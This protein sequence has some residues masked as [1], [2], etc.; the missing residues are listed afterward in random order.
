MLHAGDGNDQVRSGGENDRINLGRGN[1]W[2]V[3]GAGNDRVLSQGGNNLIIGGQGADW[4]RGAAGGDLL[5][6]GTTV[7]DNDAAALNALL[8]EWGSTR[9]LIV[10]RDNIR[11][12]SGSADRL[13]QTY[14]LNPTTIF[15]DGERN[16]LVNVRNDDWDLWSS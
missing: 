3:A 8:A 4:L 16:R 1:D 15:D 6:A 9:E 13:N 10:R 11:D 12:G 14:F 5:V 2:A 7:H